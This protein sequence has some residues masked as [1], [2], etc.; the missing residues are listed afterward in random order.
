M[1]RHCQGRDP[2]ARAGPARLTARGEGDGGC[3]GAG[4]ADTSATPSLP[5]HA[6]HGDRR[7]GRGAERS[8]GEAGSCD[9]P[10]RQLPAR[11]CPLRDPPP[12]RGCQAEAEIADET[13]RY[14]K[15]GQPRGFRAASVP[16]PP[17]APAR[18]GG[19]HRALRCSRR[20]S[21]RPGPAHRA[22]PGRQPR[23]GAEADTHRR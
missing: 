13:C 15:R 23:W 12:G 3:A 16:V 7:V 6:A 17:A 18:T 22:A 14:R 9:R 4:A 5:S 1:L 21:S 20:A 8:R 2:L 10:S 11:T 19:P